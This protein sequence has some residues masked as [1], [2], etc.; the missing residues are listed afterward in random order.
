MNHN[1]PRIHN[2]HLNRN[3]HLNVPHIFCIHSLNSL[4]TT[5]EKLYELCN[6]S[7]LELLGAYLKPGV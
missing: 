5:I 3:P 6:A 7:S 4:H 2:P 1:L